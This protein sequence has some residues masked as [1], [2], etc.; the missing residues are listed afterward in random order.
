MDW[1]SCYR[2]SIWFVLSTISF[3]AGLIV[4]IW[5]HSHYRINL[6]VIPT[7]A[8]PDAP[9]VSVIVPARNEARKISAC[10]SALFS[11]TYPALEIIVV[12]DRSSDATPQILSELARLDARL[13]VIRGEPLPE[14][15]VGKPHALAQG[16]AQAHGAW[17]C[18]LDADTLASPELIASTR[19]A[20]IATR[21]DL[22]TIL[23]AQVLVTFWERT[24]LPLVFTALA[25]G[26]DARRVNDP[27]TPDAIANG[28]FLLFRRAVYEAIGGHAAVRSS[29]VED[30][31]LAVRVKR[32]GFRLLVANGTG[33]AR[34]RMYRSFAEIWEG[35]T[36]NIY[37]GLRQEPR[38]LGLGLVGFLTSL[39]AA[40]GLPTWSGVALAAL[41]Q[42]G[43]AVAAISLGEVIILW[44]VL[45][46]LRARVD[47]A[48][49]VSR[50]YALTLPLGSLVFAAMMLASAYKVLSGKGVT[51]KGRR[52]TV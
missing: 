8:E 50:W 27:R 7:P 12:D 26:F 45:L 2:V 41:T 14:G 37:L 15:W 18:F 28:Q 35:W 6:T 34:T 20:A 4:I 5:V 19:A 31:D 32:A 49:G 9:L 51:W 44:G 17:L 30:R 11:Q 13:T 22:L 21:A 39:I 3:I 40:L 38:L 42:G 25:V 33:L 1:G 29:I 47:H 48:M 46:G 10:V 52:Y 43:G 24:L 16:A 23:T 36:K